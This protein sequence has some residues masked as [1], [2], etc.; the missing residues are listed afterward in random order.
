MPFCG[1]TAGVQKSDVSAQ[2]QSW[3]KAFQW[4]EIGIWSRFE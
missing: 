3:E 2:G 1:V 4:H